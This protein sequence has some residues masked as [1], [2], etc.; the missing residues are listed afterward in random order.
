M[1]VGAGADARPPRAIAVAAAI[2]VLYAI[3]DEFHQRSV[4]GRDSDPVDVL[5]DWLRDR[6]R[7]LALSRLVSSASSFA[8]ASDIPLI[9]SPSQVMSA[10]IASWSFA[11]SR[12]LT[13]AKWASEKAE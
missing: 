9:G 12:W 2:C 7:A 4:P 13:P 3:S 8:S 10:S 11:W 5:V 1:G 6:L